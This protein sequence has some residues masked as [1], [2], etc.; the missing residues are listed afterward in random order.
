MLNDTQRKV[1]ITFCNYATR[2]MILISI[3]LLA[4]AN[5]NNI[6]VIFVFA[7]IL[8]SKTYSNG[9]FNHLNTTISIKWK[10]VFTYILFETIH[11]RF[12]HTSSIV[13]WWLWYISQLY[14]C[15]VS[16]SFTIWYTY[17]HKNTIKEREK[18][19]LH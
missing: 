6:S 10:I 15:F 8:E 3:F 13:A 11:W 1:V 12:Y 2:L 19:Q 17:T 9:I 5:N 4:T 7:N 18:K 16:G 14:Q